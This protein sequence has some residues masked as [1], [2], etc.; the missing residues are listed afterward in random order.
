M[1]EPKNQKLVERNIPG[2]M[3]RGQRFAEAEHAENIKGTLKRIAVYFIREKGIVFVM[4]A[5]VIFG[6]LCG[7]FAPALQSSAVDIIAKSKGGDLSV[8]LILM[9]TVYLLYSASQLLQGLISALSGE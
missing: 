1:S 8:T 7:V 5:I 3:N 4:L 2:A 6:T 9:L